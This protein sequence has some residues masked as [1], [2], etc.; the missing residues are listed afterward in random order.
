MKFYHN[1]V[2]VLSFEKEI[3]IARSDHWELSV[4]IYWVVK[5]ISSLKAYVISRLLHIKLM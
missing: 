1:P 2:Y 4:L 5:H 3:G